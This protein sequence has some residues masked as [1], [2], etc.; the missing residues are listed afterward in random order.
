MR[1]KLVGLIGIFAAALV[2]GA[3]AA[4]QETGRTPG[5]QAYEV[6]A[7][8]KGPGMPSPYPAP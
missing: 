4:S 6:L 5:H 1:S 3:G 7:D 2:M 8:D